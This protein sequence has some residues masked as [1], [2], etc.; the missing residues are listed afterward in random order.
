MY[1]TLPAARKHCVDFGLATTNSLYELLHP[2]KECFAKFVLSHPLERGVE[3]LPALLARK[4]KQQIGLHFGNSRT[5]ER[6]R[7]IVKIQSRDVMSVGACQFI[8]S[9][10]DYDN[11]VTAT[12]IAKSRIQ[13]HDQ[14]RLGSREHQPFSVGNRSS[15]VGISQRQFHPHGCM[16][17]KV[18]GSEAFATR[19]RTFIICWLKRLA[20]YDGNG[21]RGFFFGRSV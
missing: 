3:T 12:K 2:N 6:G 9:F 10:T 14:V 1:R 17:F 16:Q 11:F 5:C 18:V 4:S 21:S 15:S 20:R 19:N 7:F 13:I 8:S